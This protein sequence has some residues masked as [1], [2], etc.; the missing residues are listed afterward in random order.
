VTVHYTG[1]LTDGSEFDS[2]AGDDPVTFPL[3]GVIE[4]WTE[5]VGSMNEGGQRRLIIPAALAYGEQGRPGIPGGAT[6]IFDVDLLTVGGESQ[7][8]PAT[9]RPVC[10]P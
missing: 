1:W 9:G 4:G 6:L 2:S 3:S 7:I 5:G 8:D 10:P